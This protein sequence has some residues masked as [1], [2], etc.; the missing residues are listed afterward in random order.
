MA[1]L[2]GITVERT[3]RGRPTFVRIDVRKHANL[4]PV[5]EEYG[6]EI[7]PSVQW[8]VKAKKAFT[9]AENKEVVSRSLE[10]LLNV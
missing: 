7:K 4:V 9:E 3:M 5:L 6:V 2:A 1:Q 10:E 8:S